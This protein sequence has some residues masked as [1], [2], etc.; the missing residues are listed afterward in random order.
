MTRSLGYWGFGV[1]GD[2]LRLSTAMCSRRWLRGLH[3]GGPVEEAAPLVWEKNFLRGLKSWDFAKGVAGT[4]SLP[5]SSVFFRF[6]P[7]SSFF[8]PFPFLFPLFGCFFRVLIFSF[9]FRFLPFSSV[10]FSEKKGETPFARPLLRNP[11]KSWAWL[12]KFCRTFGVLCE[13]S[14][15]G[16]LLRQPFRR[17]LRQ[18]PKG[19]AE[20]LGG[21]GRGVSRYVFSILFRKWSIGT[22]GSVRYFLRFFS[23]KTRF[24]QDYPPAFSF[25]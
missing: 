22:F 14:S 23:T 15:A 13:G 7:F 6:F 2:F 1:P 4:V 3:A 24:W 16:F 10:S 25:P 21:G 18:N 11:K 19:S 20:F 17:T 12:P 5:I 9:F 8:Y